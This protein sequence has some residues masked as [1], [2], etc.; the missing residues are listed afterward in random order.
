MSR[1]KE[2]FQTPIANEQFTQDTVNATYLRPD[3]FFFH[4]LLNTLLFCYLPKLNKQV[5]KQKTKAKNNKTRNKT[6]H[7]IDQKTSKQKIN[8]V[9]IQ[10]H[11]TRG[12]KKTLNKKEKFSF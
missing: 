1:K 12:N 11:Q 6:A 5:S 10:I 4:S 8:N 9:F 3:S 2:T 7:A